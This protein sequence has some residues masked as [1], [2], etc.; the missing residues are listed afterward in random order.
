MVQVKISTSS[1]YHNPTLLCC[2]RKG[3]NLISMNFFPVLFD[4]N[5]YV[6]LSSSLY[7]CPLWLPS[8]YLQLLSS[9]V[10]SFLP[11]AWPTFFLETRIRNWW[12]KR[13]VCLEW[14]SLK[15][16]DYLH[17]LANIATIL[18]DQYTVRHEF[19]IGGS[20][21]FP[22]SGLVDHISFSA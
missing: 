18:L 9:L 21:Y 13:K 3:N 8:P 15:P 14:R 16:E 6:S 2:T 11:A 5:F 4:W 20:S 17:L 1:L 10:F 7:L 22:N 12:E 19:S